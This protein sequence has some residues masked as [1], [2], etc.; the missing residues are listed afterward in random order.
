M[1]ELS[2]RVAN[3]L[4]GNSETEAPLEITM[5]GPKIRVLNDTVLAVTGADLDFKVI[6]N[7]WESGQGN[8]SQKRGCFSFGSSRAGS[9]AISAIN[10]GIDVSSSFRDRSTFQR[11]RIGAPSR[12]DPKC[13]GYPFGENDIP[14]SF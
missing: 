7:P 5:V 13:G 12:D 6:T 10:G 9:R 8:A 4:V 3:L 2:F 11:G 1:D 14:S